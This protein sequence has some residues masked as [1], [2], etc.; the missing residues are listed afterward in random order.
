MILPAPRGSG[1]SE[2]TGPYHPRRLAADVATLL[3]AAGAEQTIV[4]GR[5]LAGLVA[6]SMAHH[7]PQAVS[8]LV[9]DNLIIH[10][11]LRALFGGE[12][13]AFDALD[14]DQQIGMVKQ[15]VDTILTLKI[16]T[17]ASLI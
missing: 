14:A 6:L 4:W 12:K 8:G 15:V 7:E 5:R 1:G 3:K 10:P 9:L 17:Y 11:A 13:P 16:G 2:Q